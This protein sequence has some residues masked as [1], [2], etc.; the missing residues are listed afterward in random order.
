[1]G[2]ACRAHQTLFFAEVEFDQRSQAYLLKDVKKTEQLAPGDMSQMDL[3]MCQMNLLSKN[4]AALTNNVA[5]ICCVLK[6]HGVLPCKDLSTTC[7]GERAAT[8][9]AAGD[10]SSS[11]IEDIKSSKVT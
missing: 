4:V 6:L 3:L 5:E 1:L 11:D 9:N 10:E 2:Y 7:F 8:K